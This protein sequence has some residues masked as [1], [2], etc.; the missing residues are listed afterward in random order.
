[1]SLKDNQL[2]T[3]PTKIALN[4]PKYRLWKFSR[5]PLK[6]LFFASLVGN[7]QMKHMPHKNFDKL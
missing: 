6:F 5:L 1:M 2:T 4:D 7:R 3:L